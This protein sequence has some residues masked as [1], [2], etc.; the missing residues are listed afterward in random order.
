M[1]SLLLALFYS[2][3]VVNVSLP[4]KVFG[5]NN[6]RENPENPENPENLEDLNCTNPSISGF[7]FW[8]GQHHAKAMPVQRKL[9]ARKVQIG[10]GKKT[11]RSH[12]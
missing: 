7:V 10:V 3:D 2:G 1:F 4:T 5:A 6:P 11:A 8:Q 12:S 9:L